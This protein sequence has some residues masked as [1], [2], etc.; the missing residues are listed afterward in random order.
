MNPFKDNR[1]EEFY[2]KYMHYL[3][4][5]APAYGLLYFDQL[6]SEY[7]AIRSSV[8]PRLTAIDGWASSTSD[9]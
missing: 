7:L 9:R 3:K 8:D 5:G 2:D 6:H 1:I 4:S